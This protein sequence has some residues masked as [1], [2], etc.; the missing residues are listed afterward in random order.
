MKFKIEHKSN[1]GDNWIHPRINVTLGEGLKPFAV[2]TRDEAGEAV[3]E[4]HGVLLRDPANY[5]LHKLARVPEFRDF[6]RKVF[7]CDD[8]SVRWDKYA[9]CSVCPCSPGY[10]VK[11]IGDCKKWAPPEGTVVHVLVSDFH[12][13]DPGYGADESPIAI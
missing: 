9:M 10:V 1:W 5:K 13:G 12:E 11:V 2:Q 4:T 7:G 8:V 6:L 3:E